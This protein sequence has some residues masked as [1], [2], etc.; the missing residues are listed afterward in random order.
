M[1]EIGHRACLGQI[2]FGVFRL[3][4][5]FRVRHFYSHATIQL[6]VMR[7]I[8]NAKAPL[9][10]HLLDPIATDPLRSRSFGE[11]LKYSGYQALLLGESLKIFVWLGAFALLIMEFKFH[12]QQFHQQFVSNGLRSIRQK[13]FNA[14]TPPFSNSWS[15]RSQRASISVSC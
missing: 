11:T 12:R 1:I 3:G 2:C 4:N 8:D 14:Q 9:A 13:V 10:K 5:Q 15:K 6:L 7:Q